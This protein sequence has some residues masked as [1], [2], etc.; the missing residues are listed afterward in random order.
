[1]T[2]RRQMK[3]FTC[4]ATR[5]MA[6]SVPFHALYILLAVYLN[7]YKEVSLIHSNVGKYIVK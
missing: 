1:M 6:R 3:V 2:Q 4:G 5:V 7:T